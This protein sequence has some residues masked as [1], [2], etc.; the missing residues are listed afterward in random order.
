MG[1]KT[2]GRVDRREQTRD[3]KDLGLKEGNLLSMLVAEDAFQDSSTKTCEYLA[4]P[5]T[6]YCVQVSGQP[7]LIDRHTI[8]LLNI[9]VF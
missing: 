3:N 8:R 2:I 9:A 6:A 5:I 4:S 7:I 1:E